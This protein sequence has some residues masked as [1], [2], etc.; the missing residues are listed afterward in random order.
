MHNQHSSFRSLYL[1]RLAVSTAS[2]AAFVALACTVGLSQFASA[3]AYKVTNIIADGS[4]PATIV[5]ANFINPWAASAS[6]NFWI[7]AQG[8]GFIDVATAA[9]TIP[10][11][12]IVPTASADGEGSA[13]GVRHDRWSYGD[14]VA[15]AM[16]TIR[17]HGLSI[18]RS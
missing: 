2:K 16:P 14:G 6:P 15:G 9:G 5:D 11:K 18:T 13:S 1:R 3:Q 12:V 17:R 4:V 7:S 8:T 10:F